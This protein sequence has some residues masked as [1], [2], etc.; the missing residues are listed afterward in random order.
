MHCVFM[1]PCSH[2]MGCFV[3]CLSLS[4]SLSLCVWPIDFKIFVVALLFVYFYLD[5]CFYLLFLLR[6]I[7]HLHS[8]TSSFCS[9]SCSILVCWPPFVFLYN[10]L[11]GKKDC[12]V[13]RGKNAVLNPL[14]LPCLFCCCYFGAL[15]RGLM[16]LSRI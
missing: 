13:F 1:F 16:R 5:I 11:C 12:W 8:P 10:F 2:C 9:S 14:V 3:V 6:C 7:F 4:V 15:L